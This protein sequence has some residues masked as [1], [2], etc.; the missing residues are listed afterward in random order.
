MLLYSSDLHFRRQWFDWLRAEAERRRCPLLIG[1]DLVRARI[2]DGHTVEQQI[3]WV[4]DFIRDFPAGIPLFVCSG[5]HDLWEPFTPATWLQSLGRQGVYVD[6]QNASY[7]DVQISCCPQDG[8]LSPSSAFTRNA[9]ILLH[10]EPPYGYEV[11]KSASGLQ[12]GSLDLVEYIETA[13]RPPR[14]VL[15]GHVEDAAAWFCR[16]GQTLCVNISDSKG[17][18][19]VPPHALVNFEKGW[20]TGVRRGRRARVR[21]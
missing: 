5:N 4:S 14:L 9:D 7:G 12:E 18:N 6:G 15:C 19:S 21:F 17:E 1:G 2:E 20:V 10:H 3:E 11:A 16:V 13:P 8:I